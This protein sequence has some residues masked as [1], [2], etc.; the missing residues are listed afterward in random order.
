MVSENWF[1]ESNKANKSGI[2]DFYGFFVTSTVGAISA[3]DSPGFTMVRTGVGAYTIQMV[4]SKGEPVTFPLCGPLKTTPPLMDFNVQLIDGTLDAAQ[5]I[6]PLVL[7]AATLATTGIITMNF[8]SSISDPV[9]AEL[10]D[11]AQFI[12]HM[13]IKRGSANP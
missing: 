6:H 2:V 12:L 11:A 10:P 9:P 8:N 1:R 4:N 7:N 13:A 5:G 3:S